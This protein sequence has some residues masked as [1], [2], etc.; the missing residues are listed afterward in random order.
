VQFVFALI[1]V[2]DIFEFSPIDIILIYG[3]PVA[4]CVVHP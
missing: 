2:I 4:S 3:T 1:R